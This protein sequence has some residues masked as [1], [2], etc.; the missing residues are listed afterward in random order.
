MVI[1][2]PGPNDRV[3]GPIGGSR[4]VA[5]VGDTVV[6]THSAAGAHRRKGMS[7]TAAVALVLAGCS[8]FLL[9]G[10]TGH[11]AKPNGREGDVTAV[12]ASPTVPA[13]LAAPTA[14]LSARPPEVS[15]STRPSPRPSTTRRPASPAPVTDPRYGTC[16]AVK[17]HGYGPYYRGVDIEYSWYTDEDS[18]GIACE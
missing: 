12:R 3:V 6:V 16:R 17:A 18:D 11:L 8:A 2:V 5:V 13:V 10:L 15:A 1:R 7:R 9:V 14:S 4:W